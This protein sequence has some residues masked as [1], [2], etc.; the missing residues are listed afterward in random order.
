MR[1]SNPAHIKRLRK[2]RDTKCPSTKKALY[3]KSIVKFKLNEETLKET[4]L[5]SETR[6]A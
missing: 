6:Q 3:S 1:K 5:K 4:P 2:T